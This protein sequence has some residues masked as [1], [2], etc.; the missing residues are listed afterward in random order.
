MSKKVIDTVFV[1]AM[2]V[3]S[4]SD[5]YVL[6][7]AVENRLN[8]YHTEIQSELFIDFLFFYIF[9]YI[10]SFILKLP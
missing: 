10:E 2:K 6:W 3:N 1:I 5:P 8:N 9:G 7:V 4:S